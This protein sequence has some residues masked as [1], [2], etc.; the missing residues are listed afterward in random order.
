MGS[1]GFDLNAKTVGE[2]GGEPKG[3]GSGAG[4]VRAIDWLLSRRHP[5]TSA[6]LRATVRP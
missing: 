2:A 5:N 1:I 4:I 6:V 3:G